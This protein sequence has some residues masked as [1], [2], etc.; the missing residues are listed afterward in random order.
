MYV[1]TDFYK[2]FVIAVIEWYRKN[3]GGKIKSKVPKCSWSTIWWSFRVSTEKTSQR[4]KYQLLL[5]RILMFCENNHV[6]FFVLNLLISWNNMH[7][8]AFSKSILILGII[9]WQNKN[10]QLSRSQ[11]V[12]CQQEML[13]RHQKQYHSEKHLL[14]NKNL[15]HRQHHKIYL[16]LSKYILLIKAIFSA[17][18]QNIYNIKNSVLYVCATVLY[19]FYNIWK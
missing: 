14:F 15:I 9:K 17:H 3:R 13:Y 1:W 10:L 8:N 5:Y 11:L 12:F 4:S 7:F 16:I 2:A 19:K 18:S 6:L